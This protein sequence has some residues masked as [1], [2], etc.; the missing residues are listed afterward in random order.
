MQA[1]LSI[2]GLIEWMLRGLS[3]AAQTFAVG[4]VAY[5]LF[6]LAPATRAARDAALDGF[7]R[8]LLFWSSATLC[9]SQALAAGA[10]IVFLIGS[11]GASLSTA[12]SAEAVVFSLVSAG[13]A[14]ALA[15]V[16]RRPHPFDAPGALALLSALLIGAHTG[17][18]HA[19]SR[20]E[21]APLLLAAETL[22]LFAL[23]TWIGG[24]PYFVATLRLIPD[25]AR[26]RAAS[27]RF[28]F[29]SLAAVALIAATGAFMSVP[30]VAS[31]DALYQTNYGLLIS[32]KVVLLVLLLCLG[33]ANFLAIRG[34]R[35]T[36]PSRLDSVPA[37]AEAE[38]GVGLVAILCAA[39]LA[40]SP[41]AAD[42]TAARPAAVEIS[43]QF[44]LAWPRL[45]SPALPPVSAAATATLAPS[46]FAAPPAPPRS[47]FDI[48]WSEAHHHYA[49]LF[50]IAAG[51]VALVAQNG[52][53]T[54]VTRN[55][56]AL[57][58]SLAAYLFIVADEDAWPL[59][60]IG[61]FESLANP[62]IA[63]HK[64]MI[65]FVAGLALFEWRVQ[66]R[67]FKSAWPAYVF[68]LSIG[69]AAAFLLTH[70][71]HTEAKE[72]VLVEISHTP[73]A[74]LGVIAATARWLE[75]R[76]PSLAQRRLAG[77]VWPIAIAA[78]GAF[79]LLY[80]ETPALA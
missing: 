13:A 23:A 33:G 29:T 25:D 63:Q 8:R 45:Q 67:I 17:V 68:P 71:G 26:R 52:R 44:D 53:A 79:L 12:M 18:T 50:V 5:V 37:L 73:V 47:A 75:L 11:T 9:V 77:V 31:L 19:A 62:R 30:Y 74:L 61:F 27:R 72:E 32:T 38:V 80:R 42:T 55:W 34:L 15:A 21:P 54:L 24:V 36:A 66:R 70:Y 22:H 41:L 58:L 56:P 64:L 3:L 57:F 7:C 16:A 43:H 76:L 78:A 51:L 1:F 20:A 6:T 14:F 10:L 40:A 4:G 28:S 60:S 48:A 2:Y 46:A 49:A 35:R 59:G 39:A 65:A 69:A